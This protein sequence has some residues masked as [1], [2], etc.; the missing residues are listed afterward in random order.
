MR[1]ELASKVLSTSLSIATELNNL[2]A[3]VERDGDQEDIRQ[4][5]TPIGEML[6]CLLTDIIN[7]IIRQYPG[8]K[9]EEMEPP[10]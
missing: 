10:P 2:V 1:Y 7:P 8:L 9:P 4:M 6:Y 3:E 5:R